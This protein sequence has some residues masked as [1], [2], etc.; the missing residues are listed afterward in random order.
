MNWN[1]LMNVAKD[2]LENGL[3]DQ[4]E[5]AQQAQPKPVPSSVVPG[6]TGDLKPMRSI[7]TNTRHRVNCRLN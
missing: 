7:I 2:V 5:A 3:L 1:K 4:P 6:A